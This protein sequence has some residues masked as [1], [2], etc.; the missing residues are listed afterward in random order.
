LTKA[1]VVI[2]ELQFSLPSYTAQ[3]FDAVGWAT[4]CEGSIWGYRPNLDSGVTQENVAG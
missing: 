1:V 3:C 4:V 2:A